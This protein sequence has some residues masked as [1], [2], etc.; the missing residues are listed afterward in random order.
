MKRR[1]L[2]LCLA[3][4]MFVIMLPGAVQAADVP[5]LTVGTATVDAGGTGS[6]TV[7]ISNNTGFDMICFQ[8][9]ETEGLTVDS[10]SVTD[11][12]CAGWNFDYS[13][14][15]GKFSAYTIG[16]A[17]TTDGVVCTINFTADS[18]TS[19]SVSIILEED[20]NADG[21][22]MFDDEPLSSVTFVNGSVT[23]VSGSGTTGGYTA[24]IS[25]ANNT[26][27]EGED[28]SVTVTVSGGTYNA[29]EIAV[30]Y[31]NSIM[32]YKE[33]STSSDEITIDTNTA[34]KI[35]IVD[36]GSNNASGTTYTLTFTATDVGTGEVTLD[37]AAFGTREESITSDLN[38]AA[39]SGSPIAVTVNA[40]TFSIVFPADSVAGGYL[41][42]TE[43]TPTQGTDLT[44][45]ATNSHY[46]YT[47]VVAKVGDDANNATEV[48]I[49]GNQANGWTIPGASITG[50][51]YVTATVNGVSYAVNYSYTDKDG[52]LQADKDGDATYG[53]DYTY[54][55]P[56]GEAAVDATDGFHYEVETVTVDGAALA[57]NLYTQNVNAKTVTIYGS[58][59]T[60]EVVITL[61]KVTDS[62]DSWKVTVEADNSIAAGEYS[63]NTTVEKNTQATLNIIPLTGYS[64]NVT[65][66]TADDGA[67]VK[68]TQ[69][70]NTY[71]TE[72]GVT[73]DIV[74]VIER[75]VTTE[76]VF[77]VTLFLEGGMGDS[78]NQN[79]Y[80][81]KMIT[82][83]GTKHYTCNGNAMFWS[84]EYQANCYL[85]IA[86]D[87]PTAADLTFTIAEGAAETI[88]YDM[89]VNGSDIV[90][91]NDAQ[92]AYDMYNKYYNVI[93]E[94]VTIEKFLKADAD[95]SGAIDVSD[96]VTIVDAVL[97]KMQN[98]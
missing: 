12:I 94:N 19:G 10:V 97:D 58:A 85:V 82:D 48:A 39:V 45:T 21:T 2:A 8:I 40:K 47:N 46:I 57:D 30:S 53:T 64:Y 36:K 88:T 54:A 70:G 14:E 28:I 51:I 83:L 50:N 91:A 76:G 20:T 44:F 93:N 61:K 56:D 92:L 3:I 23:V 37:S 59:I 55:M 15:T 81:V 7:S 52:Q 62:A 35:Y 34:G 17:A 75:T 74:F 95:H 68:L 67:E 98:N 63:Y 66:K 13:S 60:G 86:S 16:D 9:A 77:S 65:A 72:S 5:T 32:S 80:L 73:E 1:L 38:V 42:A 71:T 87:E 25:T 18:S 4:V 6:V 90:D 27:T 11:G 96:A 29:G 24:A 26:V 22:L 69:T 41:F 78:K 89:D 31:P 33:Y 49:T 43:Q 84:D 79:M